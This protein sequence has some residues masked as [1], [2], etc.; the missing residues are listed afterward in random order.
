M[1]RFCRFLIEG[2]SDHIK[3]RR[4]LAAFP[5]YITHNSTHVIK[6]TGG[7]VC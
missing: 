4:S 7:C 3:R 5:A 6:R 1:L 2:R